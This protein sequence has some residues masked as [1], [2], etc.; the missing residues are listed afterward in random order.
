MCD[1]VNGTN[2][3]AMKYLFLIAVIVV[4]NVA[5]GTASASDTSD[6]AGLL[7]EIEARIAVL[8][9]ETG[10]STLSGDTSSTRPEA[11][12]TLIITIDTEVYSSTVPE[13]EAA[14]QVLCE[15][16]AYNTAYM[17][18]NIV[19]QYGTDELYNDVF[20]AG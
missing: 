3:I 4:S 1:S 8:Q 5:T 6:I 2:T 14:A 10:A 12:H 17:W 18:K 19:C 16:T 11:P 9:S 13:N 15:A 20:I 7:V